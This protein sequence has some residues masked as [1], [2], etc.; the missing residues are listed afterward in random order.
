MISGDVLLVFNRYVLLVYNR[1]VL[2]VYSSYVVWMRVCGLVWMC[3]VLCLCEC[4]HD[5]G[6][7]DDIDDGEDGVDYYFC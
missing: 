3:V 2:L 1:C 7:P 5:G 4:E 6:Q